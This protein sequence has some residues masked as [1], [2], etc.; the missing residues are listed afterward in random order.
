MPP[1]VLYLIVSSSAPP[2]K[3]PWVLDAL[4]DRAAANADL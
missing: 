2:E 1:T 3:S 4:F